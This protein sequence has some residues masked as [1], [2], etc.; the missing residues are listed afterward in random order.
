MKNAFPVRAAGTLLGTFLGGMA[1]T[2][3]CQGNAHAQS[4]VTLYGILDNGFTYTNNANG[5]SSIVEQDGNNTGA[6]GSRFGLRGRED[7]GGGLAAIFLLENGYTLPNGGLQQGGLLFGRQAYVG[8]S[9]DFGMVTLGRQYDSLAD[10]MQPLSAAAQWGGYMMGHAD[11]VDNIVDTNRVNNSIKFSSQKYAGLKF[12]GVYSLGGVAGDVTRNQV[13][14]LGASYTNGPVSLAA[15]YL[16]AK[17]PN[18]GFF[19]ANG[20]A[21]APGSVTAT[22]APNTNN[23]GSSRPA[24]SGFASAGNEQIIA[25]GGA[26]AFSAASVGVI[27]SNVR[28][29]DLGALAVSGTPTFDAGST[30]VFNS[31]EI[32]FKYQMTSA[33]LWGIAYNWAKGSSVETANGIGI[34]ATY[35]QFETGLDYFLS[36]RTDVYFVG[37]FQHASGTDST[38][39]TAH[40]SIDGLTPSSNDKQVGLRVALR[41]RF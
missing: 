21:L 15:A 36:K 37:V 9:G 2:L 18:F 30:A 25:A 23:I 1:G 13:L 26:Y 39:M 32:N 3:A 6:S 11:E 41:T 20:N 40:A 31:V 8:L 4:S 27:Y 38:G 24:Y 10:Y 29:G 14:S 22:G 16:T 12:G 33:L 7:L 35:N 17:D 28:F 19:G 34:G 5:H